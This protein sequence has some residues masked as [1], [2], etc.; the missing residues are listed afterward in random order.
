[1]PE[2]LS[3]T[4]AGKGLREHIERVE[5]KREEHDKRRNRTISI[6]E[7]SLLAIVAVLAAWSGYAA[8]KWSTESSLYLARASAARSQANAANLQALNDLNFDLSTFNDWFSAYTARNSAAMT[9]AEGRFTPNFRV[10]FDAWQLLDPATNRLAP[11]G[12]TYMPEYQQPEK[13]T[14]AQLTAQAESLYAAGAKAGSNSDGYIL[15]T[16][17]LA[18]I[19]FLAGIGSHFEY[20]VVRYGLAGVGSAI[21]ITAIIRLADAPKPPH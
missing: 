17:Y 16:V 3:P 19:L 7:A 1:M 12:P 9:I 8:A 21:L 13:A 10:A 11:P 2:G 4:E 18:T 15:T 20:R 14:A 5:E 6:V